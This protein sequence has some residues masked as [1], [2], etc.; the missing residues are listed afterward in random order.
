MIRWI[1]DWAKYY[2][3]YIWKS[4][5]VTKLSFG[6]NDLPRSTSFWQ[7]NSFVNL[8]HFELWLLW[9]LAQSQ[10][11]RITLYVYEYQKRVLVWRKKRIGKIL[12]YTFLSSMRNSISSQ[13]QVRNSVKTTSSTGVRSERSIRSNHYSVRFKNASPSRKRQQTG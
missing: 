9:Y 11:H 8:L 10:I 2:N 1:W 3:S 7:K 4:I 13:L 5:R 12:I 6:Q